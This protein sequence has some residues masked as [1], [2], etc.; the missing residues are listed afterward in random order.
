MLSAI[1]VSLRGRPFTHVSSACFAFLCLHYKF[2]F[3]YLNLLPLDAIFRKR[4]IRFH[5]YASYC[6]IDFPL[7]H[8]DARSIQPV[9]D[10]KDKKQKSCCFHLMAPT[11]TPTSDLSSLAP[12]GKKQQK[13]KTDCH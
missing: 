10:K 8:T 6:K 12:F 5:F 11:G 4:G 7:K 13:K 9:L 2:F 3:F 1:G